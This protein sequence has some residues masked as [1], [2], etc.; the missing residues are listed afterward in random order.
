MKN[1]NWLKNWVTIDL[2]DLI[3]E[4]G[5]GDKTF[6]KHPVYKEWQYII[7]ENSKGNGSGIL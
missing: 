1:N 3:Q 6:R 4:I 5:G 7:E 2:L